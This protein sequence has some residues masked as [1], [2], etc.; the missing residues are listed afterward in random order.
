MRWSVKKRL[1]E[2]RVINPD[3]M[4]HDT[5]PNLHEAHT[6]AMQLAYADKLF[7]PGGV[8]RTRRLLNAEQWV[9]WAQQHGSSNHD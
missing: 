1:G 6:Y 5:L 7:A 9:I 3:G 8:K 4:W 2:W